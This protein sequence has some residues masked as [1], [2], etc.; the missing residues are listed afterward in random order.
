MNVRFLRGTTAL[1]ALALAFVSIRVA[2]EPPRLYRAESRVAHIKLAVTAVSQATPEMLH[3]GFDYARAMERG[4][5]SAG[6]VR[7]RVECLLVAMQRYCNERAATDSGCPLYMDIVAGN[8]LADARL[9]PPDKRYQIVRANIDYRPALAR[10]LHRI[11]GEMAV[12]FRLHEGDVSE[13]GALATSIDRYCLAS[14]D[15]T[16]L[17]YPICVASLVWFIEGRS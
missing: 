1:L 5:C 4:A 13:A 15:K 12:D 8:I 7:L 9:I 6:A 17:S 10:E 11:Q 2:A 3:A 14:A 16:K